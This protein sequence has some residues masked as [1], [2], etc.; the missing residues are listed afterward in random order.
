MT[1]PR[2]SVQTDDAVIDCPA[3]GIIFAK[4]RAP[5]AV[6]PQSGTTG[7][8]AR[9]VGFAPPLP[10]FRSPPPP[11][12]T[13]GITHPG[14][15]AGAIGFGMAVALTFFPFLSFILS[16]LTTMVHEIGH[17]VVLWLFGY[18]AIPAFD[19][20][21]GGGV[22]MSDLERSVLIVWAWVAGW[23]ILAWWQKEKPGVLIALAGAAVGYFLM[24]NGT[25]EVL[26]ITLGGHGGEIAFA[27]LFLYRGLTGW[28]CKVEAERPLYAFLA[29][30]I[31]F[32][33]IRLGNSL[34]GPTIERTWYLQGKGG[35]D[36]DLVT[37]AQILSWRLEGMARFLMAVE[38][39]A[40][41]AAFWAASMR[42]HIGAV[43]EAEEEV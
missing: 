22:T 9:P 28:G 31:L 6:G 36:N 18:S 7:T 40:I 38:L 30:M 24:Y 5:A 14:W 17:T 42:K 1:C 4:W 2:C 32:A 8:S 12:E 39:L 11:P 10:A 41:P 13:L 29:F 15:K 23:L 16:P 21:N 26:A 3:C 20:G 34:L 37:G 27:A 33:G 43:S 25:G 19:F 35:I